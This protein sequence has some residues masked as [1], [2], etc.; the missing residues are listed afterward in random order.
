MFAD[1][2]QL[3][4]LVM[5][6]VVNAR[7]AMPDGGQLRVAA[8]GALGPD[9]QPGARIDVADSGSGISDDIRQRMFDPFFTTKKGGHGTGLGLATVRTIAEECAGRVTVDT[10]VGRGTTFHVWLPAS[11]RVEPEGSATTQP[12]SVSGRGRGERV[13]VA[14]DDAEIRRLAARMLSG[15]GYR[16]DT[17]QDGH[18]VLEKV[19]AEEYDLVV[20]DAVMPGPSGSR[21]VQHLESR[22]PNLRMLFSTGYD[23]GVF[24]PGFFSSSRRR[25][26]SKP[27]RRGDRLGAVCRPRHRPELNQGSRAQRTPMLTWVSAESPR[28]QAARKVEALP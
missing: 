24:G 7:D 2:A 25:L 19:A 28:R 1:P 27:Y 16:V 18:E 11:D 23:P 21:L 10:Q 6:L 22:R 4:Q 26:L 8:Q 14:D 20:L 12:S 3:E 13:L 9:G 5:N 17:A 15:A